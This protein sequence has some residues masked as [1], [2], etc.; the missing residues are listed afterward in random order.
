MIKVQFLNTNKRNF[1]FSCGKTPHSV[2]PSTIKV[3]RQPVGVFLSSSFFLSFFLL[4]SSCFS[5]LWNEKTQLILKSR[6]R[7]LK[8]TI[9]RKKRVIDDDSV[10][11]SWFLNVRIAGSYWTNQDMQG[12]VVA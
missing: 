12:D 3:A 5:L 7:K 1:Q 11:S 6:N 4:L 10:F 8:T 9:G 2:I